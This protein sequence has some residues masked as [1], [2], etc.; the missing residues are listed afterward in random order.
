MYADKQGKDYC[1]DEDAAEDR[2]KPPRNPGVYL[3]RQDAVSIPVVQY[4]ADRK[5]VQGLEDRIEPSNERLPLRVKQ[6]T[7]GNSAS[8]YNLG[9]DK[10]APKG[11]IPAMV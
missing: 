9:Q 3:I 4:T 7:S 8:Y 10:T 11:A 6:R 1:E 2:V 5:I